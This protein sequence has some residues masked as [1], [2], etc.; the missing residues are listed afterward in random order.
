VIAVVAEAIADVRDRP[1]PAARAQA[2]EVEARRRVGLRR[3]RAM[4][5]T[6]LDPGPIALNAIERFDDPDVDGALH[7][8]GVD[9]VAAPRPSA[10]SRSS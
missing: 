4:S 5:L 1:A 6:V 9:P 2:D 3:V 8:E 10:S 7:E